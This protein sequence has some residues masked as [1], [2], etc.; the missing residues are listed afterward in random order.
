MRYQPDININTA[1]FTLKVEQ[2]ALAILKNDHDKIEKLKVEIGAMIECLPMSINK[3]KAKEDLIKKV[4][5]PKFWKEITYQDTLMLLDEFTPLMHWKR[6]EP[7][8]IIVLDV[9]DV[10]KQRK[11]IEFGPVSNPQEE[12]VGVY[13]EKVESKIKKLADEHPTIKKIKK[14]DVLS[15]EDLQKLENTLNSP[16]LYITEKT[17]QEVYQQHKGTL[18]EFIKKI[19]GLYEFPNPEKRIAEE[20]K[21]FV[22]E[23][24]FMNADQINFVRTLQTVFTKKKHIEYKDFFDAPFTNF[25]VDAPVPLFTEDQLNQ[26][27]TLCKHLANEVFA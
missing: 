5:S 13:K 27:V 23:H 10:I 2:L 26:M 24:N 22:V 4:L 21:T 25:G 3:V 6:A 9:D 1:S 18:V 15:E 19:L 8:Q 12:Y 14:N 11:L 16:D 20:F 7:R 17:L